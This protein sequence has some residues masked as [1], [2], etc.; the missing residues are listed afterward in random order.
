MT[1]LTYKE[2]AEKRE[3]VAY[4]AAMSFTSYN[5]DWCVN[6]RDEEGWFQLDNG[7][8]VP[9]KFYEVVKEFEPSGATFFGRDR[10]INLQKDVEWF[11]NR[12][13][14][15]RE[16]AIEDIYYEFSNF[17]VLA[18]DPSYLTT[19]E[20]GYDNP[21]GYNYIKMYV[22][23]IDWCTEPFY[24]YHVWNDKDQCWIGEIEYTPN[25]DVSVRV[26]GNSHPIFSEGLVAFIEYGW[27]KYENQRTQYSGG[28]RKVY[29]Y[30]DKYCEK[31]SQSYNKMSI[32][33]ECIR[34]FDKNG[35]EDIKPLVPHFCHV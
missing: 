16:K 33:D 19:D 17:G 8:R 6:H 2:A 4:H 9:A 32:T 15:V 13:F 25:K 30:T 10:A 3:V 24:R 7:N 12:G 18:C 11:K 27:M 5:R 26:E 28:D 20:F 1:R 23:Y 31:Y 14:E 21:F 29:T 22:Q 35:K 34:T